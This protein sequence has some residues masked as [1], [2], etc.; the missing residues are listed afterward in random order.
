MTDTKQI[1][2]YNLPDFVSQIQECVLQGYRLNLDE[3]GKYPVQIG[4]V[5]YAGMDKVEVISEKEHATLVEDA[6]KVAEPVV[7]SKPGRKPK[8]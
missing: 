5:F 8:V 3:N 1:T 4:V 7:Q 6:L 2:A